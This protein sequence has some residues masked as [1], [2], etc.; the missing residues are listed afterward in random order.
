MKN[1]YLFFTLLTISGGCFTKTDKI[2]FFIPKG[3]T[4]NCVIVY[5][6]KDGIYPPLENGIKQIM[7]PA[8]GI[9]KMK[10]KVFYGEIKYRYFIFDRNRELKVYQS[11]QVPTSDSF[12]VGP[13]TT[14]TN[15]SIDSNQKGTEKISAF[16]FYVHKIGDTIPS[17]Y[18]DSWINDT[19]AK[20][21]KINEHFN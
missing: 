4:G 20:Q 1:R 12:Y 10:E 21:A 15:S 11:F 3:Y 6:C 16:V 2:D 7:V 19:L 13:G 18:N 17:N 8:S 14:I 9:A 5:N